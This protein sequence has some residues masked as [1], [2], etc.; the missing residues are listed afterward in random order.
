MIERNNR[1]TNIVILED[2]LYYNKVL[3]RHIENI[4]RWGSYTPAKVSISS[5]LDPEHFL[6]ESKSDPDILILDYFLTQPLDKGPITAFDVI[7]D[8]QL[9][10]QRC[11]VILISEQQSAIITV[12]LMN[13]GVYAYVDKTANTHGRVGSLVQKILNSDNQFLKK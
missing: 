11:K 12:R 3:T 1:Q 4:C 13:L 8:A 7:T 10:T 9:D 6:E 5:Y 2:D